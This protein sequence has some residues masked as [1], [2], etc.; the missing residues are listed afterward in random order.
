MTRTI[1]DHVRRTLLCR[2]LV[3]GPEGAWDAHNPDPVMERVCARLP[4]SGSFYWP[5]VR[6]AWRRATVIAR[7]DPRRLVRVETISGRRIGLINGPGGYSYAY[8]R[9]DDADFR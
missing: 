6:A 2:I 7:E 3:F 4:G 1:A 8:T 5:G 9:D